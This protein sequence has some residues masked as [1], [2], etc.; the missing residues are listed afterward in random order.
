M[1][2]EANLILFSQTAMERLVCLEVLTRKEI[3]NIAI[4]STLVFIFQCYHPKVLVALC[5]N[6]FYY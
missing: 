4:F 3:F 6:T 1:K 5:I 2:E